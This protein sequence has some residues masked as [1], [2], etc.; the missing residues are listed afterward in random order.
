MLV[1]VYPP[2]VRHV[3]TLLSA[4]VKRLSETLNHRDVKASHVHR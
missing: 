4:S 2:Q 1:D 3:S